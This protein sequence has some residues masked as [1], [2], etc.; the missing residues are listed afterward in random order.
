MPLPIPY[1]LILLVALQGFLLAGIFLAVPYF[2][3]IANRYLAY[4]FIAV[5]I[6]AVTYS[7]LS[8]GVENNWLILVNDIM[9]EYLFPAT[10][11]LYF[12]HALG[13]PLATDRAR[14]YL[15]IPFWLTLIINVIIDFDVD[16]NWYHLNW[17]HHEPLISTYYTIEEVG[18]LL[19]T[20]ASCFVSYRIVQNFSPPVP[21]RWFKQ[22]WWWS[23]GVIVFWV[24][25]WLL[26]ELVS[27][28]FI[29]VIYAAV[30]LLFTWVTYQGVLHFKLAEEKF[31]IRQILDH[32]A[33]SPTEQQDSSNEN[34]H[35]ERLEQL[36]SQEHLYRN[37]ELSRDLL[38]Q[39]LG[40]SN[41][42]LSQQLSSMG[43]SFSDYINQ[44]RVEEVKLL[45]VD[46]AFRPYSL[47]AIGYEA[48][49]NSKSTFYAAFKKNTGLS[50]SA[51]REQA[52]Q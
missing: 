15:L 42:Y 37:P 29:G 10:L 2:R 32:R 47:L 35:F 8:A 33:P 44:Y 6:S 21:T 16:F 22:F 19:F 23:T 17:V 11:L 7:L 20:L 14:W 45:L 26:Y 39:K 41:G 5:G 40:I 34:P 30:M 12:I 25:L 48:G 36:M 52:A 38:A 43:T 51:F 18:S 13:H 49:F 9:W 46:P 3:S 27:V 24:F 50:P 1:L 28:D 4:T 31:E